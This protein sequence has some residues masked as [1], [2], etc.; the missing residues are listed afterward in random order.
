VF[1]GWTKNLASVYRAAHC[2]LTPQHIDTRNVREAMA[3]G[4]PV[5]RIPG[6]TLNGFRPLFWE[7]LGRSRDAVRQEA[8]KRFD[9]AVTAEQFH[10]VL[11][12]VLG[13]A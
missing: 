2:S 13:T 3:C 11:I 1:T 6:P 12:S 10:N 4:C 5:V 8:E 9:P 7:A